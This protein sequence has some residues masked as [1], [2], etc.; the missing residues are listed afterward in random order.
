MDLYVV[1]GGT[2]DL[3]GEAFRWTASEGFTSLGD[4]V[5]CLSIAVLH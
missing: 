3:G 1:G 2:A 5:A 4:L